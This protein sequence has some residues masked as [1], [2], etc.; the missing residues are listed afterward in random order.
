MTHIDDFDPS[1]PTSRSR[2]MSLR[3]HA[4]GNTSRGFAAEPEN[5]ERS[6][7]SPSGEECD[8]SDNETDGADD[9]ADDADGSG[10]VDV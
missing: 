7:V 4:A 9:D 3:R 6:G 2:R 10:G 5:S 8:G 1:E